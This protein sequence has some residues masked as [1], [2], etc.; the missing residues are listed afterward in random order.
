M[1]T[2]TS[3][4]GKKTITVEEFDRLFDE[5]SDEIDDYLD[6][7]R[8]RIVKPEPKRVNVDFPP[9][10]VRGLDREANRIGISRQALIKS[11]MANYLDEQ[12]DH[13]D[14]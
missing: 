9:H 14:S 10:I 12:A 2:I 11:V 3:K 6:L 13:K 4:D 7:S 5:G 1:N 8:A